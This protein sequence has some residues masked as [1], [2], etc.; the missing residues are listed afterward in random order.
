MFVPEGLQTPRP[1]PPAQLRRST[2]K[3]NS[4]GAPPPPYMLEFPSLHHGANYDTSDPIVATAKMMGIQLEDEPVLSPTILADVGQKSREE[5]AN[6]FIQ[7]EK[8]I[9][10]RETEL[11]L[12]ANLGKT[13]LET[14]EVLKLRHDALLSRLPVMQSQA[15]TLAPAS[16]A[17]AK[18]KRPQTDPWTTD[19]DVPTSA[20]HSRTSSIIGSAS[21]SPHSPTHSLNLAYGGHARLISASPS[22]LLALSETNA[23]LI[24]ELTILRASTDSAQIDGARRLR[25]LEREIGGLKAE[26]DA[27]QRTNAELEEL[28]KDQMGEER[29]RDCEER[30]RKLRLLE[31]AQGQDRGQDSD[32][33]VRDF[34]PHGQGAD[35]WDSVA[36]PRMAR[37]IPPPINTDVT[38]GSE[39]EAPQSAYD[40]SVSSATSSHFGPIS[41]GEY[42]VVAQLYRKVEELQEANAELGARNAIVHER[43][44]RAERD[45]LEIKRVYDEIGEE[46]GADADGE[47]SDHGEPKDTLRGLKSPSVSFRTP[48]APRNA[49]PS[50]SWACRSKNRP[51]LADPVS[52]ETSTNKSRAGTRALGN[53]QMYKGTRAYKSRKPLTDTL[54]A[55][56]STQDDGGS[57]PSVVRPSRSPRSRS[58][59]KGK[60]KGK[61]RPKSLLFRPPSPLDVFEIHQNFSDTS[62]VSSGIGLESKRASSSSCLSTSSYAS[63]ARCAGRSH[64]RRSLGSELG[65]EFGADWGGGPSDISRHSTFFDDESLRAGSIE[66]IGDETSGRGEEEEEEE[67]PALA[68]LR[69]AFSP[70]NAGRFLE[71]DEHILP[72]GALRS[73]PG[74]VFQLVSHAVAM[75]PNRWLESDDGRTRVPG[76]RGSLMHHPFFTPR[77]AGAEDP[78]ETTRYPDIGPGEDDGG[79]VVH[80]RTCRRKRALERMASTRRASHGEGLFALAHAS[81]VSPAD[82]TSRG[83]NVVERIK[84]NSTDALIE[85]WIFLQFVVVIC[86]FLYMMTRRGPREVLGAPPRRA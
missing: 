80:A 60:G 40:A 22:A 2:S 35:A 46:I 61:A 17:T 77:S 36:T 59:P 83:P 72:V 49:R 7:A 71:E 1:R 21:G 20:L 68:A 65:D 55:P 47:L 56:P 6:L 66:Y 26:L 10:A 64:P 43:L 76:P 24:S 18:S 3:G 39:P 13:L 86:T 42:A 58:K 79:G 50:S 9:K 73:S 11:S 45:A 63:L 53:K 32:Q 33:E 27:S 41:S 12:A 75:R 48:R 4:E 67:D 30:L 69:N 54:F 23:E 78:W 15:S 37:Q 8:I 31:D 57:T 62:R 5:L 52:A 28:V 85:L 84:R 74:E 82:D 38:L 51:G 25:K 14:N 34:A 70:P 29:K 44:A 16:R 19:D 81:Q